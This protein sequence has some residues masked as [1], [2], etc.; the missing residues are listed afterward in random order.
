MREEAERDREG[1]GGGHGE[2][3]EVVVR[4]GHSTS[5]GRIF[6]DCR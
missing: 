3:G 1:A 6:T 2:G 4:A 5:S